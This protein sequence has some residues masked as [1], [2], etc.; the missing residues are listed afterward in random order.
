M[1]QCYF[2]QRHQVLL[3]KLAVHPGYWVAVSLWEE[4]RFGSHFLLNGLDGSGLLPTDDTLFFIKAKSHNSCRLFSQKTDI[5]QIQ[6]DSCFSSHHEQALIQYRQWKHLISIVWQ[7]S[8][9]F[10]STVYISYKG[11]LIDHVW[12]KYIFKFGSTFSRVS[13]SENRYPRWKRFNWFLSANLMVIYLA[14]LRDTSSNRQFNDQLYLSNKHF[15][16][17]LPWQISTYSG[18]AFN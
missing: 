13:I 7:V 11:I 18:F 16:E 14:K 4:I 17:S 6:D 1:K 8:V 15:N 10:G 12:D 3:G 9:N 2:C 5:C